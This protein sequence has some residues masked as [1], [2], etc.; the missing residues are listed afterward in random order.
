MVKSKLEHQEKDNVASQDDEN[1]RRALGLSTH[2]ALRR[3]PVRNEDGSDVSDDQ[4]AG[5][6]GSDTQ[7]DPRNDREGDDRQDDRRHV[8]DQGISVQT[9]PFDEVQG[10]HGHAARSRQPQNDWQSKGKTKEDG[11]RMQ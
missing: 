4:E 10:G 2:A 5:C 8:R 3:S 11:G 6:A 9:K 1:D 7:R